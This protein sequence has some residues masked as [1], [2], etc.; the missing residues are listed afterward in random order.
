MTLSGKGLYAPDND[1]HLYMYTSKTKKDFQ[2]N[3]M[4][5]GMVEAEKSKQ[6]RKGL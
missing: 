1:V 3:Q 5:V 2:G 6:T 4:D